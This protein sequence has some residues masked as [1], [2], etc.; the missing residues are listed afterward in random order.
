MSPRAVDDNLVAGRRADEWMRDALAETAGTHPHPNPRVGA[1][2]LSADGKVIARAAHQ[3]PGRPHAEADALDR[4]GTA[5][6][7][8]TLVVTLEPCAHHGRTAPCADVVVESGLARV[9]VGAVD[10]DERVDGRGLRRIEEAGVELQAGVAAEAVVDADPAYFHHRRTGR[11]LITLKFA[12]T[13]DGQVAAADASSRWITGPAA[14]TDAHRLRAD[15]DAVVV[16]AGTLRSDDPLLTVRDVEHDGPQPTPVIVAGRRPLPADAA[17]YGRRPLIYRPER[18][19]DEPEGAEVVAAWAP[20]G[21]D[22]DAVVKDL[23]DRGLLAV[24]VEGG[25][26]LARA[27]LDADLVDRLVVYIGS[28]LGGGLG[29]S[30]IAGAFRTIGDARPLRL[31]AVTRL[32]DDVRLDY[33]V[34]P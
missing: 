20:E 4:A 26:T 8:G 14:R 32:G 5:A 13:A 11:P 6:A 17:I 29:R 12:A 21:A 19:G 24:L 30:P 18:R 31:V 27:L 22:L 33:Q 15:S 7:G 34:V 23:G 2:V 10:P 25:P 28:V 1:I 16:G 9:I 3:G